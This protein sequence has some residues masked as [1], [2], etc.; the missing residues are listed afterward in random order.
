MS[1]HHDGWGVGEVQYRI[2]KVPVSIVLSLDGG[3]PLAGDVYLLPEAGR[4][5]GRE[6]VVD[7]L[8]APEPFLPLKTNEGTVLL[9]KSRIV[10]VRTGEIHDA[11]WN[12]EDLEGVPEVEAELTLAG[13]PNGHDRLVGTLR[14]DM[15]PGQQRLLDYVNA[16]SMFLPLL[17]E[18]GPALVARSFI[19]ALRQV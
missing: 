15:P 7:L 17:L 12:V 6:R 9:S 3:V 14:L 11:G 5:D 8:T 10:L 2:P 16:T 18:D 13:Q 19:T 1:T 4:H